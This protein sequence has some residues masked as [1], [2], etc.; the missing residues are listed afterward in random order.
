MVFH[1]RSHVHNYFPDR[2]VQFKLEHGCI[3]FQDMVQSIP[4]LCKKYS[5]MINPLL[6]YGHTQTA[7]AGLAKFE[8]IDKVYYKRIILPI[9]DIKYKVELEYL[10][11]DCWQGQSTVALDYVVPPYVENDEHFSYAPKLQ[12]RPLP[13]RTEYLQPEKELQLLQNDKPLVIALHGLSGGSYESYIRSF[14]AEITE[15]HNFDAMVLNAR[16]CANHTITS[17]QLFNGLWTN[18]LRYLINE[19]V[20]KKWPEKKIFLIGFSLGGAILANYLGQEYTNVYP[21]IKGA[22]IMGTPWDFPDS[23]VQLRQSLIG[24]NLYSPIMGGNLL[25]LL[26]ENYHQLSKNNLVAHFKEHPERYNIK[27]LKDFDMEFTSKLFGFNNA[28]EYYRKAS[29]NQRLLKIRV[30][31]LIVSSLDDPITG[32]SSIPYNETKL[33]PYLATVTTTIGGHLGWFDLKGRRWYPKPVADLFDELKEWDVENLSEDEIA[34][35]PDLSDVWKFDRL[36]SRDLSNCNL[37]K[38]VETK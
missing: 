5:F 12:V 22:A 21:G 17:P 26:N 11:Y 15:K 16:G 28:D 29:P 25:N 35:P 19:H 36:V 7:Y 33:N 14:L 32:S 20:S 23:S 34:H 6:G 24:H 2:L 37:H 27:Y 31:T 3:T 1:I 13:P 10:N 38:P 18:D 9:R 8:N 30:P 4:K